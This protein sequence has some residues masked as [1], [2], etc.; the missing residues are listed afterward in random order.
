MSKLKCLC[1]E[2]LSNTRSDTKVS[3]NC[4]NDNE[5]DSTEVWKCTCGNYVNVDGAWY[6]R[7]HNEKTHT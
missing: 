5:D 4:W 7:V 3:F 2:V 1:G 6:E